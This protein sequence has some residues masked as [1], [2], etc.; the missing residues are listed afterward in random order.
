VWGAY[1]R[2]P[3]PPRGAIALTHPRPPPPPPAPLP[4]PPQRYHGEAIGK[5]ARAAKTEIEKLKFGERSVA[6]ALPLVAK[7]LLGVHDALKDKPMELE[8]GWVS[9]ATG[10]KFQAVPRDVRDAAKAAAEAMIAAEEAAE[11]ADDA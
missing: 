4:P 3:P 10:W 2:P 5:G 7:M 9:A 11:D 8:L 6:E 1:R